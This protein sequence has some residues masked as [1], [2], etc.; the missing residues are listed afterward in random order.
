[1][2]KVLKAIV[3][4]KDFWF[5]VR[6][7]VHPVSSEILPQKSGNSSSVT[8]AFEGVGFCFFKHR[9]LATWLFLI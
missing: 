8:N 3:S 6:Y 4:G 9:I 5:S 2:R 7:M 1:M